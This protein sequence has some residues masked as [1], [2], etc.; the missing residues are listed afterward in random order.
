MGQTMTAAIGLRYRRTIMDGYSL[1]RVVEACHEGDLE[2]E[3][4][5]L[6]QDGVRLVHGTYP[7]LVDGDF[8]MDRWLTDFSTPIDTILA[9][10]PVTAKRARR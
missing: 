8:V 10:R 9:A 4:E 3:V 6:S 2:C 5:H 7:M 1:L